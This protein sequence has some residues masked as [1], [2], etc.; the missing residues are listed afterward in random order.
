M[1]LNKRAV[2]LLVSLVVLLSVTVGVTIAFIAHKT[3]EVKNTFTPS[4][5]ACAVTEVTPNQVYSV[6]N[7]GDTT[8]YIRVAVV[9]NWVNAEEQVYARAPKFTVDT[10][11]TN[12]ANWVLGEDGYYYYKMPVEAGTVITEKLTVKLDP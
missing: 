3:P 9:V 2:A 10:N 7:T 8:A 6:S 4:R 12:G 11:D 1:K 5:V